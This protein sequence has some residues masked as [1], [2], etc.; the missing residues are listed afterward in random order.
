MSNLI[1]IG[2]VVIHADAEGRFSLNDLHRA[3]GG[4]PS[5]RPGEFL[6][7]QQ[8]IDLAAQID[9][10]TAGFSAVKTR[11]GRGGGT[12]A[13]K[14]MVYAYAM[15]ISAVFHLRVIRTFDA[16]AVAH[17]APKVSGMREAVDLFQPFF[18]VAVLIGCDKQAAA[19][20]A[21]QA[22]HALS[23]E[24]V[25][26]LMGQTHV[27]A[28]C[29]DSKFYTPTELGQMAGLS[30]RA[31]NARLFDAGLQSKAA[32]HWEATEA[33]REFTRIFDTGK[34][35]SSGTPVQQVKWSPTV[36][37]YLGIKKEAA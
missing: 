15:W 24:N 20:S 22:V 17:A 36:L 35:H 30:A 29:Q 28:E 31:M 23:G 10:E 2:G 1:E 4:N 13:C 8:A 25:L 12:F 19:I 18:E 32:G 11:E 27:E 34:R 16:S 7:N 14:E 6:R 5:H 26:A 37:S 21:N 3:S 9:I 33:G